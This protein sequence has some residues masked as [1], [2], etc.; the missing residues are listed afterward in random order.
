MYQY[1][2][3]KM[4]KFCW[5][6]N[7]LSF[8]CTSL[9]SLENPSYDK[10]FMIS[11][12]QSWNHYQR[13]I[14][15]ECWSRYQLLYV[16]WSSLTLWGQVFTY[17]MLHNVHSIL[18]RGNVMDLSNLAFPSP[19][20]IDWLIDWLFTVLFH[21]RIF[22]SYRDGEGLENFG[23]HVWF[24]SWQGDLYRTTQVWFGLVITVSSVGPPQSISSE[25]K[26]QYWGLT[27]ILTNMVKKTKI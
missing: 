6:C 18:W 17:C 22:Y 21:T 9:T 11:I 20:L 3:Y 4:A 15:Y 5:E 19:S 7:F 10:K 27:L 26:Q 14:K 12:I 13:Y 23:L 25:D 16:N 8:W 1:I 24:D 2:Y